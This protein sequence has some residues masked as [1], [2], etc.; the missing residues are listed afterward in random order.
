MVQ[1]VAQSATPVY[2]PRQGRASISD[3]QGETS[4]ANNTINDSDSD[5]QDRAQNHLGR[6]DVVDLAY[7]FL[8][9]ELF[10][11]GCDGVGLESTLLPRAKLTKNLLVCPLNGTLSTIGPRET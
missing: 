4:H 10:Y 1:P 9:D 6:E 3:P 8:D 11:K 2:R 7:S 5:L